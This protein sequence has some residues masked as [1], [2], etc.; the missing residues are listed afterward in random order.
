MRLWVAGPVLTPGFS[1]TLWA[2]VSHA[3]W[4]RAALPAEKLH[5]ALISVTDHNSIPLESSRP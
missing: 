2:E 4:G 3:P 1:L 5:P